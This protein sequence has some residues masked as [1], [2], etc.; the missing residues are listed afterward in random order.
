MKNNSKQ[1]QSRARSALHLVC[2]FLIIDVVSFLV[3]GVGLNLWIPLGFTIVFGLI[4]IAERGAEK[5]D[6]IETKPPPVNSA[7]P[8]GTGKSS[9]QTSDSSH[10]YIPMSADG[11]NWLER[12]VVTQAY[13][14]VVRCHPDSAVF[15]KVRPF[16][17]DVCNQGDAI[18]ASFSEFQR[19]E[20]ARQSGKEK[21]IGK[22]QIAAI[23]FVNAKKP[24]TGEVSFSE[25]LGGES[26]TC[27]LKEMQF[28]D[29]HSDG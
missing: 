15:A 29:L 9:K 12:T 2:F 21:I 20:A 14:F 4:W 13:T 22:L 23:E 8:V 18:L 11:D 7:L 6:L 25:E 10:E 17:D 28:S 16:A 24:E 3:G 5:A 26:W 19:A 27:I 1:R